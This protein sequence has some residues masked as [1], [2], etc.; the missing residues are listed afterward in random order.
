MRTNRTLRSP[1][2]FQW[3]KETLVLVCAVAWRPVARA[4]VS[5]PAVVAAARIDAQSFFVQ[6]TPVPDATGYCLDVCT[7]QG[8][9]PTVS[10][11]GFDT[12][13][14]SVP[15]G[16]TVTNKVSDPVYESGGAAPPSLKLQA[17]GHAVTTPLYP[18]AV[19]QFLFWCRGYS[20]SNSTLAVEAC[21]ASDTWIQLAV[22][23][24][25]NT[26][27]AHACRPSAADGYTRFKLVYTKD[28]GNVAVDDVS[29]AYGDGAK[30]FV[31]TNRV[32]ESAVS[33]TVTNLVPGVYYCTVRAMNDE[34]CSADS[35]AACV[36]TEAAP[37]PPVIFP[38]SALTGRVDE[39]VGW[40]VEVLPTDGDPVIATR[41]SAPEGISGPWTFSDS[42]F[43]YTPGNGDAGERIFSFSAE[44]K[45]GTGAAMAV[46]VTVRRAYVA[47]VAMIRNGETYL[48][49]FD[50]MASNG[51]DN[52]WDN[53]ADPLAGWYAYANASAV[54]SYRAGTGSGTIGGLYA[55]GAESDPDRALGSLASS[56]TTW[57]YGV[58]FTN[59][60]G[61]AVTNLTVSF[62]AEQRRAASGLTNTLAFGYCVTNRILPLTQGLWRRVGA[63]CFASPLVTNASQPYGAVY[64]AAGLSAALVHPVPPDSLV[65]LR[66]RDED[67][68]G[69]DHAFAVDDVQVSW[70]VGA[71]P[72]AVPVGREGIVQNFDEMAAQE[73]AEL[74]FLWRLDVCDDQPR[75]TGSYASAGG[76]AMGV[77]AGS[78]FTEAGS[79]LF[80]GTGEGDYAVGGLSSAEAARS[81]TVFAKFRN[82]STRPI[83]RWRVR[84]AVEKYRNGLNGCAF[85]LLVSKDGEV[86]TETGSPVT[87]P[88]DADTAVCRGEAASSQRVEADRHVLFQAAIPSGGVFYLA[89]QYAVTEGATTADAQALALDDV[90]L[91]PVFSEASV[92][93]L[94]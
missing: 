46:T 87:F 93:L 85:R 69:S 35:E 31:V 73:G 37:S 40:P 67:D 24:V 64:A 89:W 57:H 20:V 50:A 33:C 70:S 36:D 52:V 45:D 78:D 19:T 27:A 86:W 28:K 22:F 83:R 71:L 55:F 7:Y 63:L 12:F 18:V 48:Q 79:Y 9:P 94:Q 2:Y 90:A 74:P 81:V 82:A 1:R 15:D 34:Q 6:W 42:T 61:S 39:A 25:S 75:S 49:T 72:D 11:E 13:P 47:A 30:V 53:A 10:C 8:V 21:D 26:A 77:N 5:A 17:S 66:W 54:T 23:A 60:T 88:S 32:V 80:V 41:V 4:S 68:T 14:E 92:M 43:S 51:T 76:T 84:Y 16:W 29:A 65:L 38:V 62:T 58:A 44:D 91:E 59:A 56:G 3:G